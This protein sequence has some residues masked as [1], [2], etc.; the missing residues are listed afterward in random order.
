MRLSGGDKCCRKRA[1]TWMQGIGRQG[2]L[3]TQ[4]CTFVTWT[5]ECLATLRALGFLTLEKE[6]SRNPVPACLY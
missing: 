6:G 1:S 5:N 4:S 2:I 3:E